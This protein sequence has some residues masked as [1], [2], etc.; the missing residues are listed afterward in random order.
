VAIVERHCTGSTGSPGALRGALMLCVF[1]NRSKS[2]DDE[3][4]SGNVLS[5]GT[6]SSRRHW[7][8]RLGTY[9]SIRMMRAAALSGMQ[10]NDAPHSDDRRA[11]VG[12]RSSWCPNAKVHIHGLPT[13]AA[14]ALKMRPTRAPSASTSKSS[15][16]HSPDGRLAVARLRSSGDIITAEAVVVAAL[17]DA[18]VAS[19]ASQLSPSGHTSMA[20]RYDADD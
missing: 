8:W 1:A 17:A 13:G 4:S 19:A 14:L 12:L 7:A 6:R 18:V 3:T 15:S 5:R 9:T 16:F 20:Q 2:C 11:S 10:S